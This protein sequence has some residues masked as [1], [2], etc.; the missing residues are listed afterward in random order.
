ME[1]A[2]ARRSIRAWVPEP[3][4]WGALLVVCV[5]VLGAVDAVLLQLGSTY[6]TGGF[7]G[8]YVDT[9][10]RI[11]GF[12]AGSA[13]MDVALALG[14]W[15]LALPFVKRCPGT[16][17]QHYALIAL[18]TL[19]VPLMLD[20]VRY[21]LHHVLGDMV[22]PLLLWVAS[23]R[24]ASE[25]MTQALTYVHPSV[26]VLIA[27]SLAVVAAMSLV[28]RI[29]RHVARIDA[30]FVAPR[31]PIV[32]LGCALVVVLASS[33][34]VATEAAAP[35]IHFGLE[36]KA[37]V[38]VLEELIELATDFDRDG[39]GL[40][41]QPAD[42]D[43][44]DPA[45][46]PDALDLPS[47]GVDENGLAGD[48]PAGFEALRPVPVDAAPGPRRPQ[49]LLVFLESF[50]ADLLGAR[51]NGRAVTP[52][53][54][55]LAREGTASNHAYVHTP[56]TAASRA[57]LFG[58]R[59]IPRAGRPTLIDDFAQLGYTVAHFSGQDDSYG[60]SEPLLGVE[61]ADRFYDARE[62]V[63]RR[64]SRSSSP[65]SLQVSCKLVN[66]RVEEYL[67]DFD[68]RRPLF[69]YVNFTDTH[70]P[71]HHREIDDLLGIDPLA[72]A[73]LN[74]NQAERI[75]E[76]YAN[77]AANVDRAI[78]RL[79]ATWRRHFAGSD[80]ALLVTSDHAQEIF[81][82]GFLGHG[83]S[84]NPYQTR[85]PFILWRIGGAWPEPLGLADVRGLLRRH[86]F[87]DASGGTPRA[88]FAP[89]RGRR[90]F[91]FA[92]HWKLPHGMA[93]RGL[94]SAS[95]YR[96][97]SGRFQMVD[98]DEQPREI[99]PETARRAFE[100]LI[101]QWEGVRLRDAAEG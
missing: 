65:V 6:F 33:A 68:P 2:N 80:L 32:W 49:F 84:V 16:R 7:N 21:E 83:H 17:A 4:S 90:I 89:D 88:R 97:D 54:D 91:Q 3:A 30:R 39:F 44:F 98:A 25:V 62:D 70:F 101:W 85:I 61:R 51:L 72:R 40:L 31:T 46:H 55:R 64:I 18:F 52:F 75:W 76:T 96:V 42:P 100:E 47:N 43:A 73:D 35:R 45:I 93:L 94:D 41:S 78:E 82:N 63:D 71:Y 48:H 60:G 77:T 14:L 36:R 29:E 38:V 15:A 22:S 1:N 69:L 12:F 53:L 24:D 26:F 28:G 79:V 37:S 20:Y 66:Q 67:A 10:L 86:L 9:P 81:E 58:G 50:R 8:L 59:L 27:A 57:Q 5:A 87:A 92:G 11:A 19:G 95:I 74:V 56:A 34:L 23:D 99:S 13:L